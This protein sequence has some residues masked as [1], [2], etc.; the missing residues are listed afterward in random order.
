MPNEMATITC[1]SYQKKKPEGVSQL[2]FW[3]VALFVF[4]ILAALYE[5]CRC[6]S[7]SC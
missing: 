1:L 5:S 3:N 4:L 7:V 2:C 6:R